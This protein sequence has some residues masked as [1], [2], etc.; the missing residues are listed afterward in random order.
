MRNIHAS[1]CTLEPL[2][3]A[4]AREMF[5]VLSDPAI[6]EFENAPPP[7]EEWLAKRYDRLESRGPDTGSEIWLNW[8]ARL[9]VGE[10]VGY[11]QATV[12]S[13][14][15]SYVAYEFC[16]R[17]WRKGIGSSAVQAMLNELQA[18]YQVHTHIAVLKAKNF[19]S[20]ALL[21]KLGFARASEEQ[22]ARHRDEPD[23]MVMVNFVGNANA[24]SQHVVM[25]RSFLR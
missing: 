6:Y 4:H 11:V 13:D 3:R 18:N 9:P 5:P 2:V 17:H 19:R 7:T 23:E 25:A 14:G 15:T 24:A 8:V 22:E 1:R 21:R 12:Q 16:S 20:D 10:L